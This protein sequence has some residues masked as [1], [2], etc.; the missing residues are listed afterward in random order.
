MFCNVRDKAVTLLYKMEGLNILVFLRN[1]RSNFLVTAL[2]STR[3]AGAWLLIADTILNVS[4]ERLNNTF[5][6]LN[7]LSIAPGSI[8]V[9]LNLS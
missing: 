3:E 4:I 8:T 2:E 5:E 7:A 1:V 9:Q 6:S